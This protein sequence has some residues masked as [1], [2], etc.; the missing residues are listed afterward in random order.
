MHPLWPAA[1][2]YYAHC[3]LFGTSP[4]RNKIVSSSISL[5][6]ILKDSW[7]QWHYALTFF[8]IT[9]ERIK[10]QM[11]CHKVGDV[12]KPVVGHSSTESH[13]PQD[14]KDFQDHVTVIKPSPL[15]TS[16]SAPG[17]EFNPDSSYI[18]KDSGHIFPA[19]NPKFVFELEIM[20]FWPRNAGLVVRIL[21]RIYTAIIYK[22]LYS[23]LYPLGCL[24]GKWRGCNGWSL[25]SFLKVTVCYSKFLAF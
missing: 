17:G 6:V 14:D 12:S 5:H 23:F 11:V 13:L 16:T 18:G 15:K 10:K 4:P 21:R 22:V 20:W 3:P 8:F 25:K 24:S 9:T 2:V 7:K 1:R 19:T